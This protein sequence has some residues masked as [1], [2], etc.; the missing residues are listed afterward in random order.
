MK[1]SDALLL[2]FFVICVGIALAFGIPNLIPY[3]DKTMGSLVKETVPR[4]TVSL[5]L[6]VLMV[7]R[8]YA[9][10]FK[11]QWRGTHLLW[12]IPC[13]LVAIVNFPFGALIRGAAVV[14]RLDLLWIFLLKCI[15]IALLE[16]IFFRALLLPLFME[17]FAKNRYCVLISVLGSSI[18]FALMH[19]FNLFFGAGVGETMVQVGYTFLIGCMLA[20]MMLKTENIWLCVIVHAVFDVGGTIVADLGSGSFQDTTFWI[21]TAVFGL[22]CAVHIILSLKHIIIDFYNDSD[23][24]ISLH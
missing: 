24:D 16:E 11:P 12:S 19:L 9:E 21:L 20:V 18:L 14:E 8:G 4:L 22:L 1:K 17:C 3:S 7:T 10:T 2:V 5:F 23:D 6:I 15:A 13:F